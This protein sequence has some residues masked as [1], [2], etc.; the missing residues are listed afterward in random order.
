MRHMH[1]VAKPLH[2]CATCTH[3]P[4]APSAFLRLLQN[5][6]ENVQIRPQR[7]RNGNR[8]LSRRRRPSPG[9]GSPRAPLVARFRSRPQAPVLGARRTDT[10]HRGRQ[11]PP[12]LQWPRKPPAPHWPDTA[13]ACA[14]ASQCSPHR[15][16]SIKCTLLPRSP[17][18]PAG[19]ESRKNVAVGM[20]MKVPLHCAPLGLRSSFLR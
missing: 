18:P 14:T 11:R 15:V 16:S 20:A 9:P 4:H 10:Q 19:C 13:S 2:S 8:L 6:D 17:H 7:P 12:N 5:C 3:A 1:F